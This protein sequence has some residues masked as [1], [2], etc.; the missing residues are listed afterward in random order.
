MWARIRA[1]NVSFQLSLTIHKGYK[2]LWELCQDDEI[3]MFA[4]NM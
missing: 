3:F 4:S 2:N 1:H